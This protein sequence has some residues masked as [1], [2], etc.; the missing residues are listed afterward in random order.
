MY[1]FIDNALGKA[2]PY[3]I[4]DIDKNEGWVNVGISSDTAK[5]AV[6]SI[7]IWWE[8]MGQYCYSN[9]K[10]LLI[11]ADGGGSNSSRSRLW[12]VELQNFANDIQKQIRVC[13]FPPGTS[14]WNKIEHKLFSFISMNWPGRPLTSI[15]VIINLI[16]ATKS[17]SGLKVKTSFDE[18]IYEKG[19]KFTDNEFEKINV[20]KEDFHGDWNYVI[21]PNY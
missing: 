16:G 2:I 17:K 15:Q 21:A 5:F 4:Y 19:I 12:K 11:T 13:H 9:A 3:G 14:K 6:S 18:N 7:R 10:E 8:Q 20:K 1:D